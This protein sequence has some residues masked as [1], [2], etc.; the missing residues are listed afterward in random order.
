MLPQTRRSKLLTV[1]ASCMVPS[2]SILIKAASSMAGQATVSEGFC[3]RSSAHLQ[4][5]HAACLPL[6]MPERPCMGSDAVLRWGRA[7]D[8]QGGVPRLC[9][10]EGPVT[11]VARPH[12]RAPTPCN[13]KLSAG[14]SSC[15]SGCLHVTAGLC[16]YLWCATPSLH[17]PAPAPAPALGPQYLSAASNCAAVLQK[18]A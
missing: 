17:S 11:Q 10:L 3:L 13:A 4:E 5:G 16:G 7:D 12:V 15:S 6:Q 18:R 1:S 2:S 8:C 14:C 9:V